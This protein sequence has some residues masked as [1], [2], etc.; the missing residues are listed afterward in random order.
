METRNE[1]VTRAGQRVFAPTEVAVVVPVYNESTVLRS[2]LGELFAVFSS[3]ICIDDAST[4][5]SGDIAASMGATVVRHPINLG[6]GAAMQTGL[7][8]ALA[9]SPARVF[10]TFDADG[11]HRPDD[12]ARLAEVV[13]AGDAEIALGSRFMGSGDEV[14]P[15]RK[16][17]LKGAV[18]F[19]R[20][21][22]GLPV[23]DAHCGLRALDRRAA[24]RIDMRLRGMAHASELMS[25][26][27]RSKIAYVEVPV[28]VLY[29]D[30]SRSKG[31][32]GINAV[33]ILAEVLL[34]GVYRK[35]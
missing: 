24:V 23:T 33:N 2:V 34:Q 8:Y 1:G 30:Y 7:T 26:I 35:R 4:D 5:G 17:L 15:L 18:I 16:L 13:L 19:T 10:V 31:Q 20:I 28:Y 25:I 27:A 11:Q 12:A 9:H 6:A 32:S 22:T 14:P 3:V 29:T 21:T